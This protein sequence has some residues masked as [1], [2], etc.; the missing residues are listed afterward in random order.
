M[1]CYKERLSPSRKQPVGRC[2]VKLRTLPGISRHEM[3]T[4]TISNV[5]GD[6]IIV[7]LASRPDEFPRRP[8]M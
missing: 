2:K 4:A 5:T 7:V 3:T 8:P 1:L 6:E